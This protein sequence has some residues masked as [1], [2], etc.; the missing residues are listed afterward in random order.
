MFRQ[1][2][3]ET[4]RGMKQNLLWNKFL[5]IKLVKYWDKYTEMHGQ[6]NVK[7]YWLCNFSKYK[8][9]LTK[10]YANASKHVGD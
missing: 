2:V 4:C 1:H 6:E 3:L 8:I 10:D 7:T 9:R 5:C